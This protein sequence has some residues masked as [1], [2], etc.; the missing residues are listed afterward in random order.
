MTDR[1]GTIATVYADTDEPITGTVYHV[2]EN[3]WPCVQTDAGRIASGPETLAARDAHL[4]A[5]YSA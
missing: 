5:I 1:V 2:R 3:G 4:A